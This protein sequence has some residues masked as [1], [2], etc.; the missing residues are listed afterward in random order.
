MKFDQVFE[1]LPA[2]VVLNLVDQLYFVSGVVRPRSLLELL[3]ELFEKDLFAVLPVEHSQL[4]EESPLGLEL[5][6]LQLR[7]YIVRVLQSKDVVFFQ[8]FELFK[9][10]GQLEPLHEL[11]GLLQ[12]EI[13]VIA[14]AYVHHFIGV[15][16]LKVVMRLRINHVL[17]L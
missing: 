2:V 13:E 7:L 16:D 15:H 11:V 12:D 14:F 9:P 17:Q 1:L 10:L 4:D 5:V 8:L 3:L 6:I